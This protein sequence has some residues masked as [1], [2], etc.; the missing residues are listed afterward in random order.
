MIGNVEGIRTPRD[1]QPLGVQVW[2]AQQLVER[3]QR[4]THPFG[5]RPATCYIHER[6]SAARDE[7]FHRAQQDP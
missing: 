5:S 3:L 4:R 1:T 2:V 7:R 6:Q